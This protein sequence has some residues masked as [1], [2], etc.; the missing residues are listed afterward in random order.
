M[1]L[2]N[3]GGHLYQSLCIW[4]VDLSINPRNYIIW[5]PRVAVDERHL[6]PT[7]D[8]AYK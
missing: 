7:E 2:G 3:E 5:I 4:Y 1:Q 8:L 6:H